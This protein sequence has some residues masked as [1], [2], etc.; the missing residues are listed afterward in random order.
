[1]H[2]TWTFS[3][4]YGQQ[5]WDWEVNLENSE[6]SGVNNTKLIVQWVS[7]QLPQT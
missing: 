1:M 4:N 6:T 2:S 5:N 3:V 7:L